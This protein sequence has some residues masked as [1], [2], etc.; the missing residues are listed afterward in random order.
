MTKLLG[1]VLVFI[2]G[3]LVWHLQ[4]KERQ[5]RRAVL[6]DLVSVLRRMQEEI[7]MARTPLPELLFGLAKDCGRDC[8]EFLCTVADAASRGNALS[9]AWRTGCE[10]LP[11]RHC[12][13]DVLMALSLYGDEEKVC[14]DISVAT[15]ELAKRAA[16]VEQSRPEEEKRTTALCFSGAALLVILLI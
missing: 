9:A 6:T 13:Q 16:E 5:R 8:S 14:K 3:G 1:S 10:K 12:E 2:G 15:Y 4:W 11:L 7:R